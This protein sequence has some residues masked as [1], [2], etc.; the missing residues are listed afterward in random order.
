[1]YGEKYL[2]WMESEHEHSPE[3]A[4]GQVEAFQRYWDSTS[5]LRRE[6]GGC[7][8]IVVDVMEP[9]VSIHKRIGF[10][11]VLGLKRLETFLMSWLQEGEGA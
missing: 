7:R 11:L 4:I 8:V 10:G 2:E 6:H 1:M 9:S 3:W 5:T